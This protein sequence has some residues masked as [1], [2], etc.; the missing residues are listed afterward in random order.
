VRSARPY[1]LD[2]FSEMGNISYWHSGGSPEALDLIKQK[3]IWDVNEF[4]FGPYF[5]RS[6]EREAP[7]NLYTAGE[8]WRL[9][10][11]GTPHENKAW[12]GWLFAPILGTEFRTE[13]VLDLQITYYSGYTV[14]WQFN[15]ETGQYYRKIGGEAVAD[16]TGASISADTI[17]VQEV[18][19]ETIDEEGRQ[20]IT[21]DG[22][23]RARVLRDGKMIRAT[24]EKSGQKDRTRFYDSNGKEIPLRPGKIWIEVIAQN[25]PLEVSN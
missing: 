11:A 24:W 5:W 21:T 23:G 25:T 17:L 2:W 1:F 4:Y 10:T 19:A 14:G 6:S 3:K 15:P 9:L 20:K 7:H 13:S 18:D 22:Q 16:D 12:E 8:K